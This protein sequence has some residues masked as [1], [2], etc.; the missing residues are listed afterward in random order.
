MFRQKQ[1]KKSAFHEMMWKNTGR[2]ARPQM[3]I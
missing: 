2:P 1:K 3:A